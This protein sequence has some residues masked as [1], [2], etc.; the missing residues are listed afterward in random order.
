MT[1]Y[2]TAQCAGWQLSYS[3]CAGWQLSNSVCAGWQLSNF[4]CA[5]WHPAADATVPGLWQG[6]SAVQV[7]QGQRGGRHR[8]LPL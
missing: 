8:F 5:G 2:V 7:S 1:V 6:S 3:V 4:V